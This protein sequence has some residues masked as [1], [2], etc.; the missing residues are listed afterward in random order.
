MN[1]VDARPRVVLDLIEEQLDEEILF[2]PADA[3][4]DVF[5]GE[6]CIDKT[7]ARA[8]LDRF[9][10]DGRFE[11]REVVESNDTLIQAL[12][13]AVVRN[14]AG[15]VL[16]LRR[17]ERRRDNPLHEKLVIWAGGHVRREDGENGVSILQCAVRELQ[18]EL[19]LSIDAKD[20]NLLGAVWTRTGDRARRHAAIVFEWRAAA[21]DVAVALSAVEFFERRGTS[22]SGTFVGVDALA[23]DVDAKQVCE[24]WS[25]EIVRRLLP[26]VG[27]RRTTPLLV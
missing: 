11:S 4:A 21:D 14:R 19:R 24:P 9:T 25:V 3:V 1:V 18:E 2:L 27:G 12:P 26:D 16:R 17:R 6:T 10:A 20:L 7:A 8:L 5:A 13:V 15:D 23:A 22:L